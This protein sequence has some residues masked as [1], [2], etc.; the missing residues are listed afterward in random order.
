MSPQN[1]S[2]ALL[3]QHRPTQAATRRAILV[4]DSLVGGGAERSVLTIAGGLVQRGWMVDLISLYP[5]TSYPIPAGVRH[6]VLS[7][8]DKVADKWLSERLRNWFDDAG[9][10]QCNLFLVNLLHSSRVVKGANL[11]L[12]AHYVIRNPLFEQQ[13]RTRHIFVRFITKCMTRKLYAG[14][15]VIAI[16]K[17][18]ADDLVQGMTR[19][20]ASVSVIYNSFDIEGI[21]RL[22]SVPEPDAEILAPFV[23]CVGHFKRQ[24]RQDIALRAWA[25]SGI[26]AD[27]VFLGGGSQRKKR[28]IEQ[29]AQNLG[30]KE[31]VHIIDW[32]SN[33][34]S[35]L[36]ASSLLLLTSDFE[37][38]G[39]VIVEALAVGTPVV[40]TDS[41]GG[42][43]EILVGDLARGLAPVG[44]EV[45]IAKCMSEI[46]AKPPNLADVDLGIFSL[47]SVLDEYER[48]AC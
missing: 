3:Q 16:S 12:L 48:K 34:Y 28:K 27:L 43:K 10:P 23:I 18:V 13:R 17:G 30:V 29:L 19:Q 45:G 40:A 2:S 14:E 7:D 24:K 5:P 47:D 6:V 15:H 11:P 46:L 25:A 9:S 35:W 20:P 8:T 21:R 42:P 37:G 36:K 41:P 4:I 38:F 31:R 22:A 39:R 32:Q 33:V 1:E 44:D 26:K